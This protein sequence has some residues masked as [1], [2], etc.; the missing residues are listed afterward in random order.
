MFPG[1]VL[2]ITEYCCHGDLLNFL[3]NKAENFLNF[4]MMIPTPVTDYKNVDT[5]R[6]FFRRSVQQTYIMRIIIKINIIQ[7]LKTF[8][9]I[10]RKT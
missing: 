5:E 2:V 10:K 1:P 8:Q 7:Y 9:Q 4:V 6:M 3:R